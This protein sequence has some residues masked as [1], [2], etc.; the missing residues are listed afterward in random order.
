MNIMYLSFIDSKNKS[1]L[2]LVKKIKGQVKGLRLNNNN[3]SY[4]IIEG[5]NL[6]YYDFDDKREI[7][8]TIDEKMRSSLYNHEILKIIKR[9]KIDI[10]YIRY[11]LFEYSFMKFLKLAKNLNIKIYIEI[12]TYPYISIHQKSHG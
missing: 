2:G 9:L 3:V 5:E 1:N 7:I 11:N 12:P 6:L 10:L 4:T 8:C